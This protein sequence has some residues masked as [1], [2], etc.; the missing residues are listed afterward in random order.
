VQ[1]GNPPTVLSAAGTSV[2]YEIYNFYVTM[3]GSYRME[4]LSAAFTTGTAD[5]TFITLYNGGSFNAAN[6]LFGALV[7]DDDAG[8]GS[9][10]LIN[11]NL[12]G[13][14]NY[15]LVVTSF[16]NG[17]LGNYSGI[18]AA[19]TGQPGDVIGGALP[20]SEPATGAL[21]AMALAGPALSRRRTR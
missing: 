2:R 3:T 8:A 1:A 12:L 4:T 21:V 15:A 10:S 18:I 11:R 16:S 13:D 7:A 5:D 20:V 6:P 14:T 17:Q 9:L 19:G